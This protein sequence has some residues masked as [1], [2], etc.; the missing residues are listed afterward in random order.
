M[1]RNSRVRVFR[2]ERGKRMKSAEAMAEA[3]RGWLSG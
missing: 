3:S 1:R 2:E